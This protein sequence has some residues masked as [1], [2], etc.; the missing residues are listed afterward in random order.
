[1]AP[2]RLV[3]GFAHGISALVEMMSNIGGVAI[4]VLVV[5]LIASLYS[6]TVILGKMS[7][8]RKATSE[9]RRFIRAFRKAT[10]LQEIAAVSRRT[11]RRARWRRSSRMS[12]RP[13]SGRRAARDRRAT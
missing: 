1:M 6:W 10:R 11:T 8:F 9:S 13:T 12:T 2:C 4:G 3:S 5:L 7:S